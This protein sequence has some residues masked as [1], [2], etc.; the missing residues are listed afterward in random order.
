[1]NCCCEDLAAEA[2]NNSGIRRNGNVRYRATAS[3]DV[4]VNTSVCAC[5]RVCSS[6]L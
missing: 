1:V 4:T 5:M 2:G 3:E 6:E